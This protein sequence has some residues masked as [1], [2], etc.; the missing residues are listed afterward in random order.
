MRAGTL[1]GTPVAIKTM[2]RKGIS[3]GGLDLF[4]AECELGLTLRHPNVVQLLGACWS[5]QAPTGE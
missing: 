1:H 3:S 5:E 4:K 2:H